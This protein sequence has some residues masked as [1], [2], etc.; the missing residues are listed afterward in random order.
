MEI[1][2]LDSKYTILEAYFHDKEDATLPAKCHMFGSIIFGSLISLYLT[3][4]DNSCLMLHISHM[5]FRE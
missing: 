1:I 5:N 3:N 2:Y 4:F